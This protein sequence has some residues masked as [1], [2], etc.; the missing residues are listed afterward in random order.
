MSDPT[1]DA[2]L[3]LASVSK[4]FGDRRVLDGLDLVVRAGEV[5]AVTGASGSGKS[6][7]LKLAATLLPPSTGSVTVLGQAPR[8]D[9]RESIGALRNRL[10]MQFQNLG[11]FAFTDVYGNL[12]FSL[13]KVGL[14]EQAIRERVEPTL[15]LLGLAQARDRFPDQISGGMKRRLAIG[16]VLVKRPELALFDDPVAGLDPLTSERVLG[17]LSTWRHETGAAVLLASPDPTSVT[18]L[19]DRHLVLADGRLHREAA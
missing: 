4:S 7:L 15:E 9:D 12:A 2:R 10:G 19:V 16:R 11:L 14:P 8:P 5:V 6:V 3:V 18:G 17:I 13:R 1:R